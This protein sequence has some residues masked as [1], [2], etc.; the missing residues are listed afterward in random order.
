MRFCNDPSNSHIVMC[1]AAWYSVK[2]VDLL[3]VGSDNDWGT[4]C[5]K[6]GV[7][8]CLWFFV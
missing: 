6:S 2:C 4:W 8:C 5:M 1:E 3:V 7:I